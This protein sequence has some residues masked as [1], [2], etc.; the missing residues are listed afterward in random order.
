MAKKTAKAADLDPTVVSEIFTRRIAVL[1]MGGMTARKIADEVG[2]SAP[3]IEAIQKGETYKGYLKHVGEQDMNIE[4]MRM[5]FRLANMADKA[6]K[7]YE[8]VMEDYLSGKSGAR[9]AVTVAQSIS[10][11]IGADKDEGK[12]QDTQLTIVLPGGKDVITF[13]A[14]T[15]NE[16]D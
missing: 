12:V 9:D 13:D 16:T 2:L 3:A 10:R 4:V 7:V 1:A 11:A 6:A 5:K 8:K 15:G 14:E